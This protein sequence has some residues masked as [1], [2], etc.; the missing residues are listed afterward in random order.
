MVLCRHHFVIPG[1]PHNQ[2][3]IKWWNDPGSVNETGEKKTGS[4]IRSGMTRLWTRDDEIVASRIQQA[5]DGD[6]SPRRHADWRGAM[7]SSFFIQSPVPR[8]Q[9]PSLSSSRAQCLVSRALLI[10]YPEPSA[11]YPEPFSFFIQSPVPRIQSPSLSLE[12]KS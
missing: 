1:P 2:T 4:R 9:S 12:I 11:S 8:I 10:L 5:E 6:T 7:M 3:M